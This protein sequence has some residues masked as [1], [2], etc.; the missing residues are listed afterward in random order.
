MPSRSPP[1]PSHHRCQRLSKRIHRCRGCRR[2]RGRRRFRMHRP[3][4]TYRLC[5][6][7]RRRQSRPSRAHAR[8]CPHRCSRRLRR[9]LRRLFHPRLTCRPRLLPQPQSRR[10]HLYQ[11]HSPRP[12]QRSSLRQCHSQRHRHLR[13]RCLRFGQSRQPPSRRRHRSM[14][15]LFPRAPTTQCPQ[16]PLAQVRTSPRFRGWKVS[17]RRCSRGG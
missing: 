5:H 15:R 11:V 4:L 16:C 2:F 12:R 1:R 17:C 14:F 3:R 10:L 13:R 7:L 9:R 6:W 8:R